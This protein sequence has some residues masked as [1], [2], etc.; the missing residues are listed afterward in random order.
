MGISFIATPA[1]FLVPDYSVVQLLQQ[2]K[3]TFG[4]CNKI[5]RV[6]YAMAIAYLYICPDA[7]GHVFI[8]LL[9]LLILLDTL[10]L[11]PR[12][13]AR[14]KQIVNNVN[15]LA[16]PSKA[17]HLYVVGEIAKLCLC[18]IGICYNT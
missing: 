11:L 8:I 2:G 5:E 6:I 14:L 15:A 9:L 3:I 4:I 18:C 1:K 7:I 10:Y 16:K 12:L 13:D 17:H